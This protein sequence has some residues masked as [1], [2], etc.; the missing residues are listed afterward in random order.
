M[1][2]EVNL[3]SQHDA[4][5]AV[6]GLWNMSDIYMLAIIVTMHGFDMCA[7]RDAGPG[8]LA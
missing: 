7:G 8:L 1:E 5:G 3:T 2:L 4:E 6:K